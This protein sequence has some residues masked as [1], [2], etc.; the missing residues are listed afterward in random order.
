MQNNNKRL[1]FPKKD[2]YVILKWDEIRYFEGKSNYSII[3]TTNNE[4]FILSIS[5]KQVENMIPKENF[6]RSHK[7]HIV[8]MNCIKEINRK[9]STLYLNNG[10]TLPIALRR[11]KSFIEQIGKN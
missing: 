8:N 11:L 7:S 10:N 3:H 6:N 4:Q 1:I 5:L 2:G 9:T